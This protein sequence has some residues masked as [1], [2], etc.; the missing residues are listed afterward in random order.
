MLLGHKRNKSHVAGISRLTRIPTENIKFEQFIDLLFSTKLSLEDL[1]N[2]IKAYVSVLET[3]YNE[4]IKVLK[5]K[6]E[7]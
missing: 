7:K 6:I 4:T 2:E 5:I 3:N 1:K